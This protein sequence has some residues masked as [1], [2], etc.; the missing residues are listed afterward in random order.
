MGVGSSS[1][2]STSALIP[3]IRLLFS[4]YITVISH[5]SERGFKVNWDKLEQV[6]NMFMENDGFILSLQQIIIM[7]T[8]TLLGNILNIPNNEETIILENEMSP[9]KGAEMRREYILQ[10][11]VEAYYYKGATDGEK[12][13]IV[14]SCGL[15]RIF[16]IWVRLINIMNCMIGIKSRTAFVIMMRGLCN[17]VDCLLKYGKKAMQNKLVLFPPPPNTLLVLYVLIYSIALIWISNI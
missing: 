16:E 11:F 8:K 13:E 1:G 17:I 12:Y 3:E 5:F 2:P 6:T 4:H 15:Y 9:F 10:L 7:K 14:K